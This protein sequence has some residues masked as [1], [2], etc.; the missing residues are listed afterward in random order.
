MSLS[1][2]STGLA[3]AQEAAPAESTAPTSTPA[4]APESSVDTDLQD[5]LM[6]AD[7]AP[8]EQPAAE[9]PAT[10]SDETTDTAAASAATAPAE[11]PPPAAELSVIPV[12]DPAAKRA[13]S[14]ADRGTPRQIEEIVVTATKREESLRDI[15]A[16]ISAMKGEDLERSGA[17]GVEDI[18]KLVPG[19][20]FSDDSINPSKVTI[21][22]ISAGT[23]S[24]P[25]TGVL[26][27]DV[28]FTDAYLP[29]VTLDPNP[30]DMAS[31][32]VLKGPQGALFGSAALNGAVRYVPQAPKFGQ[33][34]V[35]W[36]AQ[37]SMITEG[38]AAPTFGG[39]INV[40]WG[41]D[42]AF[43]GMAFKRQ[44][45]GW[46]DNTGT[47]K[48]DINNL[49]QKGARGIL[50]WRPDEDLNIGFTYVWQQTNFN[51]TGF[52]DGG[53]GKL[54]RSSSTK[55][56]PV[57]S[58][59]KLADL[60]LRYSFDSMDLV[61]DSAWVD[62]NAHKM[63]DT[64]TDLTGSTTPYVLLEDTS[65]SETFSQE[66]RLVSTDTDSSWRWVTGVVGS[67]QNLFFVPAYSTPVLPGVD[68][69]PLLTGLGLPDTGL[70]GLLTD[71]GS[72]NLLRVI[73]KAKI[74]SL[75]WFGDVTYLLGESLELSL[76][77]RYYR[78]QTDGYVLQDGVLVLIKGAPEI[79]NEGIVK[80]PGFNPKASVLWRIT[81][82][83]NLYAA[84]SKGFRNGGLQPGFTS[85][86]SSKQAPDRF[87]SD[88]LWNYEVGTRTQWLDNTLHFDTTAFYIDWKDPQVLLG[89]SV[90]HLPYLD[91]VGR[92][93]SVGIESAVQWLP[94]WV[95][96]L[97]INASGA[98]IR[99][100]T[101]SV[102]ESETGAFL[103]KGTPFPLAAEW[104]TSTTVAYQ[105]EIGN[106][107]AGGSVTH[108]YLSGS[109]VDLG[110]TLPVF[111]YQQ[112]DVQLSL[113]N[114]E[115]PWLPEASVSV[116]NLMDE[117][118]VA[119]ATLGGLVTKTVK[120]TYIQPRAVML[121]LSG[122]F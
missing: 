95:P 104:Q 117:R 75:A 76:G 43:R 78:S 86:L 46:I 2:C 18:T 30:F 73:T 81:D 7:N 5:L 33:Y 67:K 111:G 36:F 97:S 112:W 99:S 63:I 82:D 23:L 65:T 49:D 42:F 8:A 27:G 77:G 72:V 4:A 64:S 34:E 59:Y 122:S 87:K 83:V 89:D 52:A 79:V 47:G 21:R 113:N 100:E 90:L 41:E 35:R 68:I 26:F 91:N 48:T 25:T 22:G 118:G 105:R 80:E 85:S 56:S 40:P 19:V 55:P 84:A 119:N 98:W 20:T 13:V 16:S 28:S 102:F 17:R 121:R 69:S 115:I 107:R 120:T 70:G 44:S 57:D 38:G 14:Q 103:P 9:Q 39:V 92:V 108:S 94:V 96:G 37:Y 62:K 31:I 71:D 15:P 74:K 110:Q 32:E 1:L 51:D 93:K 60:V 12:A 10:A 53:N 24:N 66:L 45:P 101:A 6:G 109:H 106:W 88:T 29:R 61:S 54:T 114:P 58:Q 116:S 11:A 3:L 50:A